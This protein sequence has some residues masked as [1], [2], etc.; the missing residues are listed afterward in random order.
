MNKKKII[1]LIQA[2]DNGGCE[3]MLLRTLPLVNSFEHKI[4]TLNRL[5]ELVGQFEKKNIS[6]ININQ[7]NIFDIFSYYQLL[8]EIKKEK[9]DIIITYLFHADMIGRMFLQTFTKIKIIPFLR[10]TYNNKK[11]RLARLFEYF[12]KYFAKNYLANSKSV[13][14]FY[15]KNIGVSSKKITVIPNGIDIDF[16]DNINRDKNLRE[17]LSLG[18]K[19]IAIICVA[20]LYVNKGQKYLLEAFEEI[21][22][23]NKNIK[24]LLAG[25]GNEKESLLR[26]IENYSSKN[27]ILFLGKRNDVPQLLKI[28][29]IFVLPTLFEGMS[30]AIMEAMTCGLPVITT[31]I[32]ENRELITNNEV[33]ILIPTQNAIEIKKSLSLL[34]ENESLRKSLGENARKEINKKFGIG[35]ISRD[36][37]NF[38]KKF[39]E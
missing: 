19:D 14:N 28:S 23:E 17:N 39:D 29:D 10:T 30:N 38:I 20:N 37:N 1:H 2:L 33:G 26:Q 16:Y 25:D 13:K 22:R 27:N 11:Y 8:K 32:P 5:G 34:L 36:W 31:D 6:I 18:K 15:I 12:T 4:I 3:N 9:P 21:Y 7:R 35:K 24:L